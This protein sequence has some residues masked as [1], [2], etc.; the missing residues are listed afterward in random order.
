M[1]LL[2]KIYKFLRKKI[3]F[4]KLIP[5][6]VPIVNGKLLDGK[7]AIIVGGSGGI[8]CAI[9]KQFIENNCK[10]IISGTS[11]KK[12]KSISD[13]LGPACSYII[14][15]ITDINKMQESISALLKNN[16]VDILV[17]AAGIHGPANFWDITE[18]DY[19]SVMNINIKGM[20]FISQLIAKYFRDNNIKGHIVNIS[21]ASALKPG[22]TPY[23]ISKAAVKSFTLGLATECI[24]YGITVNCLAPGPTATNMLNLNKDS[25]LNW[26]G[27]P[28]GRVAT[29][30]EIANWAVYLASSVGNLI[31]GDSIYVTGGSGT[32]C[33]DL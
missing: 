14:I 29:V 20:F 4:E 23:E 24:K 1:L 6:Y 17:N 18:Y 3:I 8:G 32:I 33:I 10:V 28:S 26:Y 7:T 12:L 16:R 2:K 22:K 27:N 30:E 13:D 31:V 15:D 21:S 5:V 11:E 19:D 25:E 9:A